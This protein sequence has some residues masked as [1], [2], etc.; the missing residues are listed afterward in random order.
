MFYW[1]FAAEAFI[2]LGRI[3]PKLIRWS[4]CVKID[5]NLYPQLLWDFLES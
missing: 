1:S 5:M 2:F 3:P 4:S